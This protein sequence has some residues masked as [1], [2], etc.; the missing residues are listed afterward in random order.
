[1]R[2]EFE[3]DVTRARVVA[4]VAAA[5][6]F[7]PIA[8]VTWRYVGTIVLGV[9]V[10]YVTRPVFQRINARLGSRT[11]AVVAAL[12]TV[13]LPVLIL[14]SWTVLLV[15]GQLSRFLGADA[16]A[17]SQSLL[18]PYIGAMNITDGLEMTARRVLNDPS[19]LLALELERFIVPF[20]DALIASFGTLFNAGLHLFIVVVISFYLLRDDYRI[21]RWARGTFVNEDGVVEAYFS[22]IDRD[23]KSVYFGNIL[24]ALAT[25]LLGV[26]VYVTLNLFAPETVRIP[27][28]VLVGLLVGA[29]SLVPVIGMKIVWVP[30][31]VVL[32]AD[33]L[34]TDPD[35]LWFPTVFALVSVAL[36]DYIP[37][38]LLR[39]YVSG[40]SLHVGLIMLAYI[41]GPLLFGWYGIFLGPLILVITFE[42]ARI[43]FP[44]LT[45]SDWSTAAMPFST[46]TDTR[47]S[48]EQPNVESEATTETGE[49]NDTE[50]S[51]R[52][53]RK[54]GAQDE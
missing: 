53:S 30:L 4:W 6:L 13:S 8:Y 5:V 46:D 9:F 45:D 35:T 21:A 41:F 37:D 23:L 49:V 7:T 51:D 33:S 47:S 18:Q 42:F 29:G 52:A 17:A 36:V 22:A 50:A 11:L 10:Y 27:E 16:L 1:M 12:V 2:V 15:V 3:F 25:G 54:G 26:V 14:V 38:Q 40:R 39:P 19:Q 28:P 44:W 34:F 24:N 31:A 20:F 43:L 32:F 48:E